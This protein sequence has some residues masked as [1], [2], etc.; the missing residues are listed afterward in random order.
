MMKFSKKKDLII[1]V[2]ILLIAVA[3]Y[4]IY[5]I[6]NQKMRNAGAKAEIYYGSDLVMTVM[7][8]EKIDKTFSLPQNEHVIFHLYEDGTIR[9][10]ESNCPDKLCI[11]SG[12][13]KH[14]GSSAACL[15]N[16]VILKIVPVKDTDSND[17]DLIVRN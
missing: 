7:L 8:N 3:S 9:F 15:P 17:V 16:K 6:Y 1:I 5:N 13:L 14:I 11:K 12:R 4:F 2:L 10:E